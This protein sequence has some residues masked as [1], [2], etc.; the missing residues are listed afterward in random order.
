M[1]S[2]RHSRLLSSDPQYILNCLAELSS[3][4]D[5][6]F[7]GLFSDVEETYSPPPSPTPSLS[8][9][10]P[11]FEQCSP[12]TLVFNSS[13]PPSSYAASC[14]PSTDHERPTRLARRP[15]RFRDSGTPPPVHLGSVIPPQGSGT[16]PVDLTPPPQ[17]SGTTPPTLNYIEPGTFTTF[18]Q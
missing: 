5:S 14:S 2:S 4:E 18:S 13:N 1:A 17:G 10:F 8:P 9:T 7:E 12:E 15:L 16:T 11:P 3:G 6:D